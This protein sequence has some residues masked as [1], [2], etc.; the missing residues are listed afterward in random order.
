[1]LKGPTSDECQIK[2]PPKLQPA[3]YSKRR[4]T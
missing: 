3:L 4:F 2:N 1:M